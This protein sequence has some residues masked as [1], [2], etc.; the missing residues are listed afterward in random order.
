MGASKRI[1]NAWWKGQSATP[2][3]VERLGEHGGD[4]SSELGFDL[5]LWDR[6]PVP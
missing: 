1:A 3:V 6:N 4:E 2:H 5:E